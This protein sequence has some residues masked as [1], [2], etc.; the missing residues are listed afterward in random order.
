MSDDLV[1]RL[2]A[3][4][5][6]RE[7]ITGDVQLYLDAADEIER[8][9]SQLAD[10]EAALFKLNSGE[11]LQ[12]LMALNN[13]LHAENCELRNQIARLECPTIEVRD[14]FF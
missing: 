9:R 5:V 10:A 7:T 13:D 4:Y 1:T 3:W 12:S 6:P 8:L 11:E 14:W 2:R